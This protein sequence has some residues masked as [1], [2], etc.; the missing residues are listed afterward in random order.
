MK[1]TVLT[2]I[3]IISL[4][5]CASTK[6]RITK[7]DPVDENVMYTSG[8]ALVT[9]ENSDI[10]LTLY[11]EVLSNGLT[12]FTINAEN[13]GEQNLEVAFSDF[14]ISS[15]YYE[16]K[17]YREL[18][19]VTELYP[20]DPYKTIDT[21]NNH[22]NYKETNLKEKKE[23]EAASSLIHATGSL[24][25]TI[26]AK[27]KAEQDKIDKKD[28]KYSQ[29]ELRNQVDNIEEAEEIKTLKGTV[30]DFRNQAL[31]RETIKPGMSVNSKKIYFNLPEYITN[32][33]LIY[34]QNGK[35]LI[36]PFAE[37]RAN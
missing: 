30:K 27:S 20:V 17:F 12:V 3:V 15:D 22:L 4:A 18:G 10:R 9:E 5:A 2:L 35:T 1:K 21:Y 29:R 16:T 24:L 7:L 31:F 8:Y 14:M 34:R 19:E 13:I 37:K 11:S 36:F 26:T 32:I 6:Y 23:R 28:E 25:A 33:K